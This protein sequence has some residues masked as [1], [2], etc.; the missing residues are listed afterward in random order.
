[1]EAPY[2]ILAW[3][4]EMSNEISI[5]TKVC[6]ATPSAD[7]V[8]DGVADVVADVVADGVADSV[9]SLLLI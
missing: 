3:A 5:Q 9:L 6:F 7:G 2:A 4:W 8:A 1:M